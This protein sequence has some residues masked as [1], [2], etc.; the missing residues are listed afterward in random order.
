MTVI[1]GS[2]VLTAPRMIV[3]QASAGSASFDASSGCLRWQVKK[4]APNKQLTLTVN[5]QHDSVGQFLHRI[6]LSFDRLWECSACAGVIIVAVALLCLPGLRRRT[7]EVRSLLGTLPIV[8][9]YSIPHVRYKTLSGIQ[10]RCCK[11]EAEYSAMPWVR[12]Q[13]VRGRFTVVY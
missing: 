1:A 13:L 10:I 5:V 7:V 12:Y 8:V 6:P 9:D 11:I 4:A 2:L 3:E